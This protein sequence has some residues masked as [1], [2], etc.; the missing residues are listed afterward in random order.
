VAPRRANET[1]FTR[2]NLEGL[3]ARGGAEDAELVCVSAANNQSL[4]LSR[5]LSLALAY[6]LSRSLSLDFWKISTALSIFGKS[7]ESLYIHTGRGRNGKG[8][9]STLLKS[10]LGDYFLTTDNTFL[11]TLNQVKQ[12]QRLHNLKGFVFY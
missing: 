9:L 2:T 10:L 1:R 3:E 4:A 7:F 8:V 12:I 5:S 6:S 11:T